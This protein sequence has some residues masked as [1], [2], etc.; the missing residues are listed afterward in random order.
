[1]QTLSA[2]DLVAA[3]GI[4]PSLLETYVGLRLLEP[5]DDGTYPPSAI[6]RIRLIA[7][8]ESAHVSPTVLADLL[9]AGKFSF[10]FA[11][12]I[13]PNPARLLPMTYGQLTQALGLPWP[14]VT[15]M[16]RIWGVPAPQGQDQVRSDDADLLRE[17]AG[18]AMLVG[19]YPDRL[20]GGIRYFGDNVRRVAESQVRWFSEAMYAPLA[21]ESADLTPDDEDRFVQATQRLLDVGVVGLNWLYHRHL[22]RYQTQFLV[23]QIGATM[24]RAGLGVREPSIPPTIA[25]L[26]LSGFTAMTERDGDASAASLANALGDLVL[27]VAERR[28]RVVK[29]LGDGVMFYFDSVM[30]AVG[31]GLEMIER[32]PKLGLPRARMAMDSG[33]VIFRDA[34]YFGRAVNVAARVTDFAR[35]DE[36]LLTAA[37]AELVDRAAV[38]LTSIGEVMLKGLGAPVALWRARAT[39]ATA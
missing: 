31:C 12:A 7:A 17:V 25:F 16:Y 35:P 38:E 33:P 6:E 22:E 2:A 30:G 19:P 21:T 13:F 23:D 20:M 8:L 37:S 26:D 15:R 18:M 24:E 27:E 4:S 32:A 34:D 28:G 29:F 39:P 11:D 3:G 5:S 1:M 14:M 36:L 9:A 10:A